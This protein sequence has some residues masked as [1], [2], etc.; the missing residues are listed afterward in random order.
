MA[1]HPTNKNALALYIVLLL[2]LWIWAFVVTIIYWKE[3]SLWAKIIA[4][5][6]LLFNVSIGNKVHYIFKTGSILT[7]LVVYISRG[8][9]KQ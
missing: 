4:I 9:N 5:I 3:I 2:T 7:L 1:N 8:L 6:G